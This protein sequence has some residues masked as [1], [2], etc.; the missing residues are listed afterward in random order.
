MALIDM[1][2][3][4]IT[5]KRKE[6]SK[7][8]HDKASVSNKRPHLTQKIIAAQRSIGNTKSAST[9]Q[10]KLREIERAQKDLAD[11][12]KRIAD[13]ESKIARVSKEIAGEETKLQREEEREL[14]KKEQDESKRI[15]DAERKMKRVNAALA[16]HGKLHEE[17][18]RAII[19]LQK[20]PVRITVLFLASNPI[21]ASPLRLDEEAREI[22]EMIRKS[23]HRDSVIFETRWAVRP[24]DVLQAI[25]ELNP[26]IIHFSGHGSENDEIVFQ[27]P[28]GTAKHVSKE[29]IV[30]VMM[31]AGDNI[32][33]VF[34]NTC[35][36]YGQAEALVEHVDAAIGMNAPISDE[37]A[38][39]FAAQFYSSIGFGFSVQKAFKQAQAALMLEGIPEDDTP[40]LYT[41]E[42]LV[43][44]EIII[45][46][47]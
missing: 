44:D 38:R 22:R 27:S 36:S 31:T 45:V 30:R 33:L 23:E 1:Y 29:A 17:T 43:A 10:S 46:R 14:K 37:A 19:D 24:Q 32:K 16:D 11:I 42:G 25:N 40:E 15:K 18:Q 2:R 21:N 41:K 35:F 28:D 4:N 13:I 34:F 9:V 26:T 12:D 5:R 20:V 6:L 39:V 7:L 47:P 8:Q 3:N